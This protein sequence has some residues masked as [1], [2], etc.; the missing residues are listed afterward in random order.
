MVKVDIDKCVGCNAC[1]RSCP[2]DDAN[3]VKINS[4]GK[5]SI[6][7]DDSKCINCGEC[8][9]ACAH[10][11]RFFYDDTDAFFE[12]LSR[13]EN[14]ALIVAPSIK[15]AFDGY[16]RHVL[17]WLKNKGVKLIY[18]GSLGADICTWAHVELIKKKEVDKIITQPCSA[19]VN[20]I[21]KHR[22]K[23]ISFLSPVHS[24]LL[25]TAIYMQKYEGV[26]M[27]IAALTP[28]IA[29]KDEFV[30]TGN[31]VLY[32]VTFNSLKKYI[33]KED[34]YFKPNTYSDFE[35][36]GGQ[37]LDGAFYPRP[38]GLKNNILMHID[39]GIEIIT[40]EGVRNVYR[41]L[42]EYSK[43]SHENLPDVFDV[44]SCEFGCNSG[45]AM[46]KR[47]NLFKV[48]RVMHEVS[49]YTT[50]K[51]IEQ[52]NEGEDK[53]FKEFSEKLEVGDFIRTYEALKA[54]KVK[55]TDEDIELAFVQLDKNTITERNHNCAA[56]GY[57]TCYEMACAIAKGHNTPSNC[58]QKMFNTVKKDKE[59]ANNIHFEIE[60]L[61]SDLQAVVLSLADNISIV[62]DRT[63]N[64]ENINKISKNDM[65]V[66]S[67]KMDNLSVLL[68]NVSEHITNINDGI[69]QYSLMTQDIENIAKQINILALNAA[70]EAVRAGTAGK[71]FAVVADEVRTLASSSKKALS[72][73]DATNENIL[74]AVEKINEVVETIRSAVGFAIN[75]TN[76]MNENVNIAGESGNSINSSMV[77][78]MEIS[79]K[80]S[81]IITE[82]KNILNS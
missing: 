6:A 61:T 26:N 80:V 3:I 16:W 37:G 8:V 53:Q 2:A 59:H 9:R 64:I 65:E 74:N 15:S 51:R 56:C 60:K 62:N 71:G 55:I 68:A 7:I 29:K 30:L 75:V 23:L 63:K 69:K 1:I 14:I 10:K 76:K 45:A 22:K 31:K 33:E 70:I 40:S 57:E 48:N 36:D 44:L 27:K 79:S 81:S 21:L 46:G 32:N 12:A 82:T 43:E 18:D 50:E 5:I 72:S 19:I 25:C 11:A 17:K 42:D 52:S 47:H 78:V 41:D 67:E 38:G 39:D 20:Y 54:N 66:L 77:D 58:M 4:D 34:A 73:A 13:G 28:C 49:E 24:P 35:F